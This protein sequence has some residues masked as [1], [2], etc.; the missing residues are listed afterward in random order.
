PWW[1]RGEN[2]L[3]KIYLSFGATEAKPPEDADVI[4]DVTQTGRSLEQNNLKIL[5]VVMT[6]TAMLIANKKAMLDKQKREKIYDILTL[7]KGVVDARERIHIFVNVKKENLD[8]L[9]KELPALKRPTISPLS[10]EGWFSVNTVIEKSQF[11]K[12]LP[13]LRRLAQGLVVHYPRQI[14]PLEDIAKDEGG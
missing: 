4:I 1:S 2:R 9:V 12:I 6:S 8:M 11:L 14:L 13:T 5:D 10:E 3:A 7:L